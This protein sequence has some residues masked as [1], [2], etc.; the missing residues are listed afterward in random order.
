ML[1]VCL[2]VTFVSPAKMD[3]QIEMLSGWVT[4]VGPRNHVLDGIQIPQG[5]GAI[6]GTCP[7]H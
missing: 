3:K 2:L 6:F 5:E 7:A 4:L 1:F